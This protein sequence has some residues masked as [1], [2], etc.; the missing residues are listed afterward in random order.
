MEI[1]MDIKDIEVLIECKRLVETMLHEKEWILERIDEDEK[2][3]YK[4][5][6]AQIVRMQRALNGERPIEFYEKLGRGY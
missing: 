1:K 4:S 6:Q 2:G 5:V 3:V